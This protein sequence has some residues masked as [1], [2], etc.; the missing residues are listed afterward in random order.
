V[1][2]I[3]YHVAAEVADWH[4]L[5]HRPVTVGIL[6]DDHN[7]YYPGATRLH[8]RLTGDRQTGRLLGAQLVGQVGAEIARRID[9]LATAISYGAGIAE[10]GDL[11]PSYTP[12]LGNPWDAVQ[13]A[14][15]AWAAHPAATGGVRG[16][17]AG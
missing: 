14:A 9:V 1:C 7:A 12:P 16:R 2:G 3:P 8:V 15:H 17:V 13:R 4:D 6:A 11:D 5:A 10:L